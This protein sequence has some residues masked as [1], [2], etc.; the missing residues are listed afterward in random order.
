MPV[1]AH[2]LRQL[3]LVRRLQEARGRAVPFDEIQRYLLNY[4]DCGPYEERTFQRDKRLIPEL[5]GVTIRARRNQGY[6]IDDDETSATEHQQLLEAFELQEFLRLPQAL[7]AVVQP[8]TRR[9]Q[10]LEHLRPLL[11]A[12]QAQQVVEFAYQKYGEDATGTRTVAPLLLKEFR[13][14]WY[15]L[16]Q[17]AW[18]DENQHISCFG[19]DRIRDLRLSGDHFTPPEGFDAATYYE[20]AFGISRPTDGQA[21]QDIILSFTSRQGRYVLGYPLH[22]SQRVVY[23]NAQEIRLALTVYDTPELRMELLSYGAAVTIVAP[24]ALRD[25]L[26]AQHAAAAKRAPAGVV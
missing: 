17:M 23:E 8:E 11:R 15:L 12:A 20:H 26:R 2:L 3:H 24:A 4:T 7:A 14:R 21:P 19:L 25:A 9:P 6:Y 13:G 10:G 18:D 5:F 22:P 1:H 16:G